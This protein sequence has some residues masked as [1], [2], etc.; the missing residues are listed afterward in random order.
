LPWRRH[1]EY[2]GQHRHV[3]ADVHRAARLKTFKTAELVP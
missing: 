3:S 2:Q 1:C